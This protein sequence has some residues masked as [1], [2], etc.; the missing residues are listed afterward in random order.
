MY[1]VRPLAPA[2]AEIYH[3]VRLESLRDHPAAFG[4]SYEEEV[5]LTP[6]QV[7]DKLSAPRFTR[8]GG[9]SGSDLVGLAGLQIRPGLKEQ[10]KAYLFSMYV[11]DAHRGTELAERLVEAVIAGAREAGA[12]VI[13]LSVTM[14][15]PPAQRFYRRMGFSVYGI[16]HRSLKVDGVFYDEELMAL[17]LD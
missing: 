12:V 16:E 13:H 11:H 14:G 3:R 1:L 17:D 6:R 7:V 4:S 10:H 8:F 9:F 15:N 5:L 2:D